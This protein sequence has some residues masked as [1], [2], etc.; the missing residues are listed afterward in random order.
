MV[1]VLSND[2]KKKYIDTLTNILDRKRDYKARTGIRR[3][4]GYQRIEETT[5]LKQKCIELQDFILN[6]KLPMV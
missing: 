6:A 3:A 4:D 2:L 5:I 1:V